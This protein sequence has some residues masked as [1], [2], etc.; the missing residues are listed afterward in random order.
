MKILLP[1]NLFNYCQQKIPKDYVI[2]TNTFTSAQNCVI[3]TC[4]THVTIINYLLNY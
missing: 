1:L 4:Y 3:I 2:W